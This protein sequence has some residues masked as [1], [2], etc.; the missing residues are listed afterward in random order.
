MVTS[1][2]FYVC[3]AAVMLI[4]ALVKKSM[5]EMPIISYLLAISVL[6]FILITAGDLATSS[7]PTYSSQ[8]Y[9]AP[10]WSKDMM[11]A[12]SILTLAFYY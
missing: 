1:R 11:S 10:I 3:F 6:A 2:P 5:G 12:I 4:P 9:L 8:E 7:I